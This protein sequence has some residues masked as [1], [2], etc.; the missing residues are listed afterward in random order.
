VILRGP[1]RKWKG[2]KKKTSNYPDPSSFDLS[3]LPGSDALSELLALDP[4]SIPSRE[5]FGLEFMKIATQLMNQYLLYIRGEPHRLTEL[6]FYFCGEK[7]QDVFTH[8]D[9]LQKTSGNW[10]FHKTGSGYKGGSY[11]GLDIT[12]GQNGYGGILIRSIETMDGK[13]IEGPSLVVDNVLSIN[14]TKN[15]IPEIS[16]F[17][18]SDT[19]NISVSKKGTLY[20][21]KTDNLEHR[22]IVAGPRYGL[23][24]KK[25]EGDRPYYIM[26]PYRF[27]SNAL[28]VRKGRVNLVLGLHASGSTIEQ[29][30]TVTGCTQKHIKNYIASFEEGKKQTLEVYQQKTLTTNLLCSLA[31][32]AATLK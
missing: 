18:D 28:Q 13:Y 7:H 30:V 26:K 29:I 9:E 3:I 23:T 32:F 24:L 1:L 27:V 31:G 25:T 10:Y 11:K 21:H 6:E 14:R 16:E 15:G 20:L 17:V 8:Q 4:G 2:P 22:N 19:F 5:L 12:F